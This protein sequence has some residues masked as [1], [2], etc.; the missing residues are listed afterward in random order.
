METSNPIVVDCY[1]QFGTQKASAPDFSVPLEALYGSQLGRKFQAW[2]GKS[3]RRYVCSVFSAGD[4]AAME[5][6]RSYDSA[7]ILAI[8][9]D[10]SGVKTLVG[11]GETGHFPDLFW[12]GSAMAA[13]LAQG[14]EEFHVHLMAETPAARQSVLQDLLDHSQ[15]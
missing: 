8:R 12:Y 14:V 5:A 3:G 1:L 15:H 13:L 7:V 2:S 10:V 6:A 4:A 9:C 11:M